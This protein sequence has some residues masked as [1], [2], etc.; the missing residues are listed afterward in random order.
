MINGMYCKRG[1]L[2]MEINRDGR[3]GQT[4]LPGQSEH[5][6]TEGRQGRWLYELEQALL[7]KSEKKPVTAAPER[8]AVSEQ[9]ATPELATGGTQG[10]AGAG[11]AMA[12]ASGGH[13]ASAQLPTAATAAAATAKAEV[14]VEEAGPAAAPVASAT[15]GSAIAG[16]PA[17]AALVMAVD[18]PGTMTVTP[19]LS[20]AAYAAAGGSSHRPASEGVVGGIQPAQESKPAMMAALH[21]NAPADAATALPAESAAPEEEAAPASAPPEQEPVDDYAARLLHVYQ[22]ADGVQAWVRDA[23]IGAAQSLLLAR[24]MADELNNVGSRLSELTVN[25]KKI[26]SDGGSRPINSKGAM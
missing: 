10:V 1:W 18:Q 6:L 17:P 16:A 9:A 25:G 22:G 24:G 15:L 21:W 13:G 4:M 26:V 11:T 7:L 5:R 23:G 19:A 2:S 3:A 12:A 14:D 20:L 8:A